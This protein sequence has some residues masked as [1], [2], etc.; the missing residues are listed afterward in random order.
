MNLHFL[1]S[2]A[3]VLLGVAQ[4]VELSPAQL[5]DELKVYATLTSFRTHFTQVK[6]LNELN[7]ELKSEGTLTVRRPRE[8]IWEV[9]KPTALRLTLDGKNLT[10]S[11]ANSETTTVTAGFKGVDKLMAWLRLDAAEIGRSYRV[12][13]HPSG[14][15]ECLPKKADPGDPFVS[16]RLRLSTDGSLSQL[17]LKERS[18][19]ALEISFTK[20][21]KLP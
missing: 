12:T 6:K 7:L 4:G 10:L 14:E 8:V 20:P 3:V 17:N 16:M 15:L 9:K 1:Y 11:N 2:A 5:Y 19:D 21:E 13:R 18:G